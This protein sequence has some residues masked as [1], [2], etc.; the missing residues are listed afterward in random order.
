MISAAVRRHVVKRAHRRC[1]YCQRHQDDSPLLSLQVEHITARKHGGEDDADNLALACIDCNLRKGPNLTGIDPVTG[2]V[3][4]LFHPRRDRWHEHFEWE[5]TE[6]VG[7]T[8]V[9][10]T[11]I[12]V[13]ELNS[14]DRIEVRLWAI[15]SPPDPHG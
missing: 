10:R 6:I 9:G 14:T 2:A 1:E 8:A 5:G 12:R 3:T 11:T 13:L 15:R 7:L 4:L